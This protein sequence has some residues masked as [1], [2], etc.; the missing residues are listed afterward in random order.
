[1]L[2]ETTMM[3]PENCAPTSLLVFFF[4]SYVDESKQMTYG[5]YQTFKIMTLYIP[6]DE[7]TRTT[8]KSQ[9]PLQALDG[10]MMTLESLSRS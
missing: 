10:L 4:G 6:L 2:Q 8:K 3:D 9:S 7:I 5:S 1:M